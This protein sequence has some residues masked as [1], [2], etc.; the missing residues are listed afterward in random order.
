MI[1]KENVVFWAVTPPSSC[2][3]IPTFR[4]VL[5]L[6][7]WSYPFNSFG[8]ESAEFHDLFVLRQFRE[9]RSYSPQ[10]TTWTEGEVPE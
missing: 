2:G 6:Q 3:R 7:G 1:I 8:D 10:Q 9:L 5:R 4:T